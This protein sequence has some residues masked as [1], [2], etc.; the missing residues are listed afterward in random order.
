MR[1]GPRPG[2]LSGLGMGP[3]GTFPPDSCRVLSS[4]AGRGAPDWPETLEA[5]LAADW[6]EG[7]GSS[8]RLDVR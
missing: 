4:D 5:H 8:R 1:R 2:C 6:G 3:G 7:V